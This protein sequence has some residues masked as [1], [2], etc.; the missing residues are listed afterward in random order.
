VQQKWDSIY[1]IIFPGD[2]AIKPA[3][4]DS[5]ERL[6]DN[7]RNPPESLIRQLINAGMRASSQEII[8]LLKDFHIFIDIV[9]GSATSLPPPSMISPPPTQPEQSV[10]TGSSESVVDTSGVMDD[11]T[12]NLGVPF[13]PTETVCSLGVDFDNLQG[14]YAF[15]IDDDIEALCAAQDFRD[16]EMTDTLG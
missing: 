16:I 1:K 6:R 3:Y 4:M 12:E 2:E 13:G 8:L 7:A 10:T 11:M 14:N 5:V 15:G 9:C